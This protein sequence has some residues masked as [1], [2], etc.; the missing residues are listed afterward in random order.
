MGV[1]AGGGRGGLSIVIQLT[2]PAGTLPH[3][4]FLGRKGLNKECLRHWGVEYFSDPHGMG[5]RIVQQ[6]LIN[7]AAVFGVVNLCQRR[8]GRISEGRLGTLREF[9]A[10]PY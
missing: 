1:D 9:F 2:S 10:W 5:T 8:S 6:T 4:R 3:P 7:R